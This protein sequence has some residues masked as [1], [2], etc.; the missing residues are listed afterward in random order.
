MYANRGW[1]IPAEDGGPEREYFWPYLNRE[2]GIHLYYGGS[3]SESQ[4]ERIRECGSALIFMDSSVKDLGFLKNFPDK[5]VNVFLISDETYNSL[6][7]T[8]LLLSKATKRLYRDYPIHPIRNILH[9][10]KIVFNSFVKGYK[11]GVSLRLYFRA[12]AAGL[13]LSAK[14]VCMYFATILTRK[15]LG[16]LPLGYT[17]SYA[18]KFEEIYELTSES[19]LID[20]SINNCM[21]LQKGKSNS[22]FFSGQRGNFDRQLMLAEARE[23]KLNLGPIHQKFGGPDEPDSRQTAVNQYFYGLQSNCYSLCPPGN[24]SPETFRYIESLLLWAYPLLPKRVL[25]NPLYQ[26]SMDDSWKSF[27]S[28]VRQSNETSH[29]EF[30]VITKMLALTNQQIKQVLAE[31]GIIEANF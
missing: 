22:V 19:S 5:T 28:A 18:S 31:V 16:Y 14:Q 13:I 20:F 7:S 11:N 24:Y 30:E 26:A 12:F 25:S 8:R 3:Q 15:S 10:P 23:L 2:L 17:G 6:L 21:T 1:W 4:L 9:L 29:Y 27:K